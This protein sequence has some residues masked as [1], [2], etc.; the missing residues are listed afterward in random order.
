MTVKATLKNLQHHLTHRHI[1]RVYWN[2]EENRYSYDA[3]FG[4]IQVLGQIAEENVLY[5][6][7]RYMVY[8]IKDNGKIF[9]FYLNSNKGENSGL[10][11]HKLYLK[12]GSY[13]KALDFLLF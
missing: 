11:L 7:S 8:I 5:Y 9:Q 6:C 12:T 4:Y 3:T 2:N 1:M 13:K 10:M